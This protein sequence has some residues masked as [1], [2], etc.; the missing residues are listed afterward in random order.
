MSLFKE[1]ITFR[2][3]ITPGIVQLLFIVLSVVW[4][5]GGAVVLLSGRNNSLFLG[6]VNIIFGPLVLR[7]ILEGIVVRFRIYDTLVSIQEG[8]NKN[9][10]F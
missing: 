2:R 7:V 1:I 5:I 3:M 4:V 10:R 8:L 6:F 9:E